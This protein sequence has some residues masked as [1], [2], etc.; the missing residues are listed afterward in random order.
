[1]AALVP[2]NYRRVMSDRLS[3]EERSSH[4][5][6][7]RGRNTGPE[8]RVRQALHRMGYRFRL[9]RR[10]LPGSPDIVLL[11]KRLAIFVH[12]CFWHQHPGCR[13][14]R[15]PKS[16]LDYWLPKLDRNAARD[17]EAVNALQE[18]GWRTIVIWECQTVDRDALVE[19]LRRGLEEDR[20]PSSAS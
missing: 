10:G 6:L 8:V 4:M 3:P 20:Q 2:L 11:R 16:R 14:A 13:L 17:A 19:R 9:H 12:G 7:I 5:R 18:M 15:L 1:M